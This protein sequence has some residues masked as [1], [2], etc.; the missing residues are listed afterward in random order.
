MKVARACPSISHMVFTDDSIFVCKAQK[1]ECHTILKTLKEYLEISG[2]LINF[3]KSLNQF[4]HKFEE[5][6]RQELRDILGILNL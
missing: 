1:E 5:S 6:T 4:G 3:Q 2:Q